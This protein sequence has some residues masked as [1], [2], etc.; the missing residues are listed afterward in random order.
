M[1]FDIWKLKFPPSEI[2]LVAISLNFNLPC[3]W[4]YVHVVIDDPSYLLLTWLFHA[5]REQSLQGSGAT[6]LRPYLRRH[7]PVPPHN[8]PSPVSA[9]SSVT[10]FLHPLHMLHYLHLLFHIS[11]LL[12]IFLHPCSTS[13][14]S[15]SLFSILS[16]HSSIPSTTFSS[17]FLTFQFHY[18]QFLTTRSLCIY[19]FTPNPLP[20]PSPLHTHYLLLLIIFSISSLHFLLCWSFFTFF[21]FH[22]VYH[23]QLMFHIILHPLPP[24]I[25]APPHQTTP[26]LRKSHPPPHSKTCLLPSIL[27]LP[28]YFFNSPCIRNIV[29]T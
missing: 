19:F 28:P 13:Y 5:S 2:L 17:I 1:T 27:H 20:C 14:V 26:P 8:G 18:I 15:F 29:K 16:S 9:R 11:P 4:F 7:T 23:F 10:P 3:I 12:K 24:H 21:T 25:P 6:Y 22:N